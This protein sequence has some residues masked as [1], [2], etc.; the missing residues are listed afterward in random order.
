[1][2]FV[3]LPLASWL[4]VS[5]FGGFM[6]QATASPDQLRTLVIRSYGCGAQMP[7]SIQAKAQRRI[8]DRVE[9]RTLQIQVRNAEQ[10]IYELVLSKSEAG[11]WL[12]V[13]EGSYRGMKQ[14]LICRTDNRG[15]ILASS[16]QSCGREPSSEIANGLDALQSK[17]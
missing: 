6:I 7:A 4:L 2:N 15:Q 3:F 16:I 10:G 1:M 11:A 5:P 13:I 12:L 14:T 17:S 8:G 9:S